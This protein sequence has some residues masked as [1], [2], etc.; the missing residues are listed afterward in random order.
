MPFSTGHA[1]IIGVGR[2]QNLSQI[3]VPIAARD[4]EAVAA[5]LNDPDRCAY[6]PDQVIVLTDTSAT[7][8]AVLD[9]LDSLAAQLKAED[10]LFLFFVGHGSSGTDG[11]YYLMTHDSQLKGSRVIAGTGVSEADLLGRLRAIPAKRML[12][13]I[14]SCHSGELSPNFD[15]QPKAFSSEPPPQKFAEA[16]LATG[17]GRITITA[18]RPDQKS[19]IGSGNLSIF[20]KALV[21]GLQGEAPNNHGYISAFGLYEYIYL[22]AKEAAADLGWNQEPELTVIK[23]VGPFPVALYNGASETGKFDVSAS[24]PEQGAVHQVSAEKSQRS[25]SQ[26]QANLT[27]NGAIAQGPGAKAVGAGGVMV[28]GDVNGNIV[29]GN[30]NRINDR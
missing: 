12:M 21:D 4:A 7:R 11:N 6:P 23:G 9:A 16:T 26:Y 27:G 18:C 5:V 24:I 3:D 1:L 15:V 17:E 2:Y 8:K 28:D 19:W 13:V 20:T 22:E 14:N 25:Y 10:T 30:N 29:I